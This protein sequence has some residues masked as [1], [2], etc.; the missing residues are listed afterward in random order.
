VITPN[1]S[2]NPSEGPGVKPPVLCISRNKHWRY[3]SSYHVCLTSNS[4]HV[5]VFIVT[6]VVYYRDPGCSSLLNCSSPC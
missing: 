4:C 6:L 1:P 2:S 5:L 3:I